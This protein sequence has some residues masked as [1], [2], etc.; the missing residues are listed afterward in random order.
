M[1]GPGGLP[2]PEGPARHWQQRQKR[3]LALALGSAAQR[4]T[5]DGRHRRMCPGL[6]ELL[7]LCLVLHP[8]RLDDVVAGNTS[9]TEIK[10]AGGSIPW[11]R[12]ACDDRGG[13]C[14]RP[15]LC[16]P[17]LLAG[18]LLFDGDGV[19]HLA[20][21]IIVSTCQETGEVGKTGEPTLSI[22]A[23]AGGDSQ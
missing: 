16:P 5:D 13:L 3:P 21:L 18:I 7:S 2:W 11:A 10:G 9:R 4:R 17:L 1:R 22:S 12:A 6:G 19:S 14:E 23:H 8:V 20:F 15:C